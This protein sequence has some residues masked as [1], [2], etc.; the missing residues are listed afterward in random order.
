[1]GT[2]NNNKSYILKVSLL[3]FPSSAVFASQDGLR[4][5]LY[6]KRVS[7]ALM[8]CE[9]EFFIDALPRVGKIFF[10]FLNCV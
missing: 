9:A 5:N 2:I 6:V 7:V 10:R 3:Q 1:M 8:R 4:S